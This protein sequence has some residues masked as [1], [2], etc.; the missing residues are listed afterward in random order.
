M[1]KKTIYT[2]KRLLQANEIIH[3]CRNKNLKQKFDFDYSF[4]L[5]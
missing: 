1:D 3:K 2:Y 5:S 4:I